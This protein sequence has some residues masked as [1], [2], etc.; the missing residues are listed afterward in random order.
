MAFWALVGWFGLA[1]GGEEPAVANVRACADQLGSGSAVAEAARKR[2]VRIETT[3]GSGSGFFVSP[4]GFLLTAGHVVGTAERVD[5]VLLDGTKLEGQVL[6]ANQDSDVALVKVNSPSA[7][8]CFPL[9]TTRGSAGTDL[10]VIG[11]PGG[12]ALSH[13]VSKGIISGYREAETGV[14]L[15]TDAAINSGN[16]GGVAVSTAGVALGV[17]SFKAVGTGTEGLGFAVA[18]ESIPRAL[19]V[20]LGA[21][22]DAVVSRWVKGN[23]AHGDPSQAGPVVRIQDRP[24]TPGPLLLPKKCK[25]IENSEDTFSGARKL[26]WKTE[27]Y[28]LHWTMGTAPM[29][30]VALFGEPMRQ[31]GLSHT[32]GAPMKIG[33]DV[34]IEL[35]LADGTLLAFHPVTSTWATN[36][37]YG[38]WLNLSGPV[39]EEFVRALGTSPI[40]GVRGDVGGV[41]PV[42]QTADEK[43]A[44]KWAESFACI[45]DAAAK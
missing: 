17:V 44:A 28:G 5:V 1:L 34:M 3:L 14:I 2:T 29:L 37:W 11:S 39:T 24:P 25:G 38:Y 10:Y 31:A 42:L 15:Q 20:T 6:R 43:E 27:G 35:K 8:P 18:A 30:T 7:T 26:A 40:R 4:D 13:S 41:Q 16:S 21:T 45:A 33:S 12:A 36:G 19:Y 32:Y 23:A 22:S 9:A